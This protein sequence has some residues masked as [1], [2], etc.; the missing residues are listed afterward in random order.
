M[1]GRS[2]GTSPVTA[3]TSKNAPARLLAASGA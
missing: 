1:R 2:A 3:G